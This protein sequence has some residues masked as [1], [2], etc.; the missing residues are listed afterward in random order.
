[1]QSDRRV[2]LPVLLVLLAF[3]GGSSYLVYR[4]HEGS[5]GR[6]ERENVS[7]V[8]ALDDDV[9][10]AARRAGGGRGAWRHHDWGIGP[11][12]GAERPPGPTPMRSHAGVP[13]DEDVFD[14]QMRAMRRSFDDGALPFEPVQYRARLISSE[15]AVPIDGDASCNVRILPVDSSDYNCL[16]R[17]MCDGHV[18]YP[19]PSQTAG[20][21]PCRI[22]NGVP[23][24]AVDDG[25]TAADGDPLVRFDLRTRTV[26]VEDRGEGV[27]AFR[28]VLSLG[29]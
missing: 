8:G 9:V 11:G 19:N 16:V 15:G 20:Y 22:E 25:H 6:R 3:L 29:G 10:E 14:P 28:A 4:A 21:A 7:R 23:I 1:M 12:Q 26:T 18:L 2:R 13:V 17:V 24:G 27:S 5:F